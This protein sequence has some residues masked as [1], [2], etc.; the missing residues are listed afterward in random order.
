MAYRGYVSQ[1]PVPSL[2]ACG[3]RPSK[4]GGSQ[5]RWPSGEG[6]GDRRRAVFSEGRG[7][8]ARIARPY[9]CQDISLPEVGGR[10]AVA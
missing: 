5:V 3:A 8:R 2:R 4:G 9:S 7:L 10:V 1:K 6:P